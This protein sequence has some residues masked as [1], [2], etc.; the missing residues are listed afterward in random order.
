MGKTTNL[1]VKERKKERKALTHFESG[2]VNWSI[3][4]NKPAHFKKNLQITSFP[5]T[6]GLAVLQLLD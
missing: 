4:I 6:A 3:L 1:S 5:P 2:L